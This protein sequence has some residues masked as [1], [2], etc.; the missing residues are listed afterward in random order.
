MS[1]PDIYIY[2][3]I[4]DAPENN[5][6]V[7]TF[8]LLSTQTLAHTWPNEGYEFTISEIIVPS[9]SHAKVGLPFPP[10]TAASSELSQNTCQH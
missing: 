4:S 6:A 9:P 10:P 1:C 5:V 8:P 3:G 2:G 7:T